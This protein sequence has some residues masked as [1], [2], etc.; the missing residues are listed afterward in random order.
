MLTNQRMEKIK[1]IFTLYGPIVKTSVLR[2]NKLCS[3]DLTELVH[4]GLLAKIKTGYYI[5]EQEKESLSDFETAIGI[6]PYGV[7]Y[8][9]SAAQ[10]YDLFTINPI[11]ICVAISE[12]HMR[13]ILPVYPPIEI[14][15]LSTTI[16]DLGKTEIENG[17]KVITIYNRERTV[18]DFFRQRRKIGED[19]AIEVL[20]NYMKG[21]SKNIQLLMEY[22]EKLRI[23]GV[24]KPYLEAML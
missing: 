11:S 8:L 16:F 3:R 23:K 7:I 14:Y 9:F 10:H 17:N 21:N 1:E 24:I 19:V 20:K 5:L 15:K 22:A 13:P 6:I 18:C 4:N 2:N 12:N